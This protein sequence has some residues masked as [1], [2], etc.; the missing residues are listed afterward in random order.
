[1]IVKSFV[2]TNVVL[3]TIGQ[4]KRKAEVARNI[5]VTEVVVSTQVINECVNV[6]LRKLGFSKEK[7]YTFADNIMRRTNVI[8]VDEAIVRKSAVIA[9]QNQISNWDALIIAAALLENCDI[10]YTEDMQHGQIFDGRLTVVNP[11]LENM[12]M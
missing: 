7:S 5:I 8:P 2:D 1:M 6:C 11:F 3:Y 9:I 10:L 4:D 12:K